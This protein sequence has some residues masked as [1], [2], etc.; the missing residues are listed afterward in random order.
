MFLLILETVEK[1]FQNCGINVMLHLGLLNYEKV[2]LKIRALGFCNC[3]FENPY[4]VILGLFW[5]YLICIYGCFL[6]GGVAMSDF[7]FG[8]SLFHFRIRS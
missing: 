3:G 1:L 7:E 8:L 4:G 5:G 2:V 6:P